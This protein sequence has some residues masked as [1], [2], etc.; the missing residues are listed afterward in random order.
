MV[1][2][3]VS[4]TSINDF[5]KLRLDYISSLAPVSPEK[6]TLTHQ[7]EMNTEAE[8]TAT[9]NKT[10]TDI[11]EETTANNEAAMDVVQSPPTVDPSIHLARPPGFPS[12]QMIATVATASG[13]HGSTPHASTNAIPSKGSNF[14][15]LVPQPVAAQLLPIVP[16][17]VQ[18]Q[19][20]STSTAQLDKHGQPIRKP[21]HYEHSIQ[22]KTQQ[23]EEIESH[24][25]HKA[26][27][28]DEL[29]ARCTPPPS[30]SHT[31]CGKKP[32]QRTTKRREQR[33]KQK[34]R[35]MASQASST[36]SQRPL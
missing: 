31:E 16:M 7:I 4:A 6:T 25:A 20:P 1:D 33:A 2:L 24:K 22:R 14:V 34:E 28:I 35:Q 12:S 30:T 26:R 11:L 3:T 19:Q 21:A 32:S 15:Q 5:L 36:S 10:L 27:T 29:H 8:A 23:Q 9:S 18:G 17:D 13:Y